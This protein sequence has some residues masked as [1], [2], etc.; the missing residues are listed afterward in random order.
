MAVLRQ[1]A[2]QLKDGTIKSRGEALLPLTLAS[3]IFDALC[4]GSMCRS[5]WVVK[6]YYIIVDGSI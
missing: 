1:R 5:L 2:E 6:Y 3:F 4:L